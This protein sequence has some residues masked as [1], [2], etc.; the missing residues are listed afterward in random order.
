MHFAAVLAWPIAERQIGHRKSC[1]VLF[2]G[3]PIV[4][5]RSRPVAKSAWIVYV[6]VGQGASYNTGGDDQLVFCLFVL[7]YLSRSLSF[8]LETDYNCWQ[9]SLRRKH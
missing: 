5:R 8:E 9:L 1:S 7:W 4:N 3:F 6:R 2:A